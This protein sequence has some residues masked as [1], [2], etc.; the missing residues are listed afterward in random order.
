M[1]G[2]GIGKSTLTEAITERLAQ[3]MIIVQIHGSSSLSGVPFGVLAPYTAE[4]TAEDSVSPVAVLRSVWR[5]FE[6]LKAG[7]DTPLLLMMDDA[8][9]LD[10]A[11]AG[12]VA[13]M[14]SAGWATVLAA[15]RPRPGL[16]QPLAQLWYDGLADRVDLRP[17]NREQI[18]EVLSHALD[19][20]VPSGTIDTIW[21]ASGGNPR[22]L[23][24]LLHDAAE[25]GQLA[26]RNG[27]W[28]LLGPLPAD[29]PRLTE[30]VV[31]D[32]L[33]RSPEEQ[34]VLKLVALAGPVSRKVIEDIFGAELVRT[35]LDQQ[36]MVEGSGIPADLRIWNSVFGEALRTSIS[37]SRSLQLLEKIQ[38]QLGTAPAGSEGRMRAVEW[39]LE[40]GLKVSDPELLEAA[41]TALVHSR[42]RSSRTMAAKVADPALMPQAQAI[43]ARALFNEGDFVGAAKL[44]DGCWLKLG[45]GAWAVPVLLLRAMAHQALGTP[46]AAFAADSREALQSAGAMAGPDAVPP[47]S[48]ETRGNPARLWQECLLRLLELGEAGNHQALEAEVQ[49]L[50][51]SRTGDAT[52]D[53]LCAVG[54]ALLAHSLASAGRSV[55]GLDTA[56]LAASELSSLQ[57]GV[58]FF[59][60]FVLGR[61]VADYLAMGEWDSAERELANYVAG[62]PRGVAYFGGSLEVLRGYSL[63]RQGRMERAYQTLLPAVE[64]LRLNDPL[65]LFRFGSGLAFYVAAR[66]G[67]AAQA[68]RLELDYKDSPQGSTGYGIL[69]TAYAAAA[70]EYVAHDGKG[71][72][73]LHTLAT[74]PEVTSRA[75]TLLEL[76]ALCWDLGDHSV[77]PL[78]HSLAGSVEGRWAAAM[79][80]LAGHWESGDADAIM[81]TAAMLEGA[82]FVNLAREAYARSST[83]L[84]SFG[85]RRRA[86]QAVA[87]RE[88]CDHELGERFR[89]GHFIAAAPSVHLTRR[90]QDI[91]EL[92]VKGLTDREIA[93]KLMVSV[94]TVEGHLY[95]TYV[96]LGVR[97][98]DELASALPH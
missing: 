29:G 14:I 17:M 39:S 47:D 2:P 11:T 91:V 76:L 54:L 85:E 65:Q 92:A 45:N 51:S 25:R 15:G 79:L 78:V 88:K 53:A 41:G 71:L 62:Q 94:R 68:S 7:R 98:R 57:G 27:I 56:L 50:R 43:Q 35:L 8:H 81:D 93:Q 58:F 4:L 63:L 16:P 21:S 1:A 5:Y 3:E 82:G 72:A 59:N 10:E 26:K 60:E 20:T 87:L 73:S 28:M 64:T 69:A 34:E 46:L 22:I 48:E 70:S 83:V 55:Q 30:V 24:A 33:R 38:D 96:K 18:E 12:I 36:M 37:V 13:D 77:I 66:L 42:N 89:E 67:D 61:L 84:E 86:R 23:D 6:K 32:M 49:E 31:K 74:T 19:G 90:E 40:C 80:A 44:L 9:H 95:R 75:G 52:E 97:S